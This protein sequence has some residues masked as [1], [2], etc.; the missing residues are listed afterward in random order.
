MGRRCPWG[1]QSFCMQRP[2]LFCAMATLANTAASSKAT[3]ATFSHSNLDTFYSAESTV[4]NYTEAIG[5]NWTH[6]VQPGTSGQ[7][8]CQTQKAHNSLTTLFEWSLLL[9]QTSQSQLYMYPGAAPCWKCKLQSPTQFLLLIPLL[10][11]F[12]CIDNLLSPKEQE[13]LIPGW[14][15]SQSICPLLAALS[16]LPSLGPEVLILMLSGT[17]QLQQAQRH[18]VPRYTPPSVS[19][20]LLDRSWQGL[21]WVLEK[22]PQLCHFDS[23]PFN[24][25][26]DQPRILEFPMCLAL[27]NIFPWSMSW[28]TILGFEGGD[29][30][31]LS[32]ALS[33][34]LFPPSSC[35]VLFLDG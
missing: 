14:I 21:T 34:L 5:K 28:R 16:F 18:P 26:E 6:S 32:S 31:G 22:W 35:F 17:L 1:S 20:S 33:S 27:S 9:F 4:S 12:M 24:S 2:S 29:R 30:R 8:T 15:L 23:M 11:A 7:T 13:A 10:H 3:T 19:V 25:T